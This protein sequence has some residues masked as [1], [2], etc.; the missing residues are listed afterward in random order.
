MIDIL[1]KTKELKYG[2]EPGAVTHI[3]LSEGG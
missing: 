1:F 2:V 3:N